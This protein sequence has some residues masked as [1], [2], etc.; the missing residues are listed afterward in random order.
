MTQEFQDILYNKADSVAWVT[1]NR[2][3]VLNAFRPLTIDEMLAAFQDAWHDDSIG[4]MVLS[5]AQGHFCTGGDQ[6]IRG[7]GGYNDTSGMP[8][9]H[10]RELH[11]L[12][13]EI[14]KP[15][16]AMVD[17]Y[18]IGGGHVLHVLCDLT[19]ASSHAKFGQT[20]PKVGSFDAGFGSIQLAR[21]VGQKRAREIW[22]LCRQYTAQEA[23]EMGLVNKV[24]PPEQLEEETK[25][26]CREM[27]SKS[28]S[29][30]R[31]LKYSFNADT[32]YVYG[33]QAIAHGATSLFY[34]TEESKEGRRAFV[35]KRQPD[36][37]K[38]RQHPW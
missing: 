7:E 8:R 14:P 10:V 15:V 32:D 25:A 5:G 23:Y 27:L 9:L 21:M 13:R 26:W 31:F 16:V 17:G 34:T 20:G 30:L 29:A 22:Y 28:P 33:L 19:I 37:S 12:I 3:Q 24:V 4:V 11:R 35:E 38:Y 1:I 6:K 36:F 18:C 2:P